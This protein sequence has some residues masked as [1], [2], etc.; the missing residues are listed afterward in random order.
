MQYQDTHGRLTRVVRHVQDHTGR[1]IDE[2]GLMIDYVLGEARVEGQHIGPGQAAHP[3]LG[4]E[5]VP[6]DESERELTEGVSSAGS[7]QL[8]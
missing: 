8:G 7:V 2:C 3:P 4:A 1:L 5:E 6:E